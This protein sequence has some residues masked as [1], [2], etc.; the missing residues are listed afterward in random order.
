MCKKSRKFAK[1]RIL[2]IFLQYLSPNLHYLFVVKVYKT[3]YK[4]TPI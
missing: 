1:K 2:Q 3:Y 4:E